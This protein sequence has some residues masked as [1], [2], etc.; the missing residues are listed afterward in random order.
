MATRSRQQRQLQLRSAVCEDQLVEDAACTNRRDENIE[1]KVSSGNPI[2]ELKDDDNP[3]QQFIHRFLA[4]GGGEIGNRGETYFFAQALPII[5]IAFGGIP[6]LSDY[7]KLLAGPGMMLVGVIVMGMTALDMGDALTPWPKP[8]G[9]GLVTSGLYG[10]VRHPMYSGLL[11]TLIGFSVWTGSVDRLLMVALLFLA[12]EIKSDYEEGELGK[13]YPDYTEYK[14][15]VPS[16]F[17]PMA[18]LDLW[19]KS[20][21]KED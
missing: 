14:Q 15:K 4:A 12:L 6:I 13:A 5:G 21:K 10:Q 17:I 8:N 18:F 1:G 19:K 2:S 9:Q 16:K 11:A 20:D 7:L 3:I